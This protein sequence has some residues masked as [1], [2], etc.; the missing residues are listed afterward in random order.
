[1]FP[2][3][4]QFACTHQ[5]TTEIQLARKLKTVWILKDANV[6]KTW[7]VYFVSNSLT[8]IYC[9]ISGILST[10]EFAG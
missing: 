2:Q 8:Q 1:M 10:E 5:V 7:T 3:S 4:L 6:R 9:N